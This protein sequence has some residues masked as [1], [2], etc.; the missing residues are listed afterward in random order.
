[1]N[2]I[3]GGTPTARLNLNLREDKHWSYGSF[4]FFRDARG[5]RPFMAYAPVQ[6]D[7]TVDALGELRK[8]LTGIVDQRPLTAEELARAQSSLTLTLPGSW[9]TMDDVAASIGEIV[10][11]GLDD[12]YFDGYA[13]R[14][15][16]QTLETV[17]A[18]ARETIHPGELVWVVVGDRSKIEPGIRQLGLGDIRLIDAD[19]K[20]LGAS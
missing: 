4:S 18:A 20:P 11:F 12:R 19:G 9:E 15:R 3:L 16:A 17:T 13:G 6:T 10:T 5:Q 8:E 14:I 2:Q 1:M 7:K